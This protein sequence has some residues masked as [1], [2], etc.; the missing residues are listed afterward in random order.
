[1]KIKV[2]GLSGCSRCA[3]LKSFLEKFKIEYVFSDCDDNPE[4]CDSLEATTDSNQYPMV[5]LSDDDETLIEILYL[6][7]RYETLIKG[8]FSQ[9]GIKFIPLY[10]TDSM[11]RY[12][13]ARLNL[14][15]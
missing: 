13:F 2:L 5:L 4:N 12:T 1:M 3:D 11:F 15:I 9:N 7:E 10:S 6:T 8:S 14:S